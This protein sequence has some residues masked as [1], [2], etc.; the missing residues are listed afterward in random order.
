MIHE[1]GKGQTIFWN[2]SF[3]SGGSFP[4]K[5][6]LRATLR[7]DCGGAPYK[8]IPCVIRCNAHQ[9]NVAQTRYNTADVNTAPQK[10]I[11][12]RCM[13]PWTT[14]KTMAAH[15]CEKQQAI[16]RSP[17]TTVCPPPM[18]IAPSARPQDSRETQGLRRACQRLPQNC[19]TCQRARGSPPLP[20]PLPGPPRAP[21]GSQT[22]QDLPLPRALK[23]SQIPPCQELPSAYQNLSWPRGASQGLPGSPRASQSFP[24]P[25]RI[26]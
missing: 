13:T 26:S 8:M 25:P 5:C 23:A 12:I 21:H 11:N 9:H 15:S 16:P 6:F 20:Q 7:T 22:S 18:R 17:Q 10:Y 4:G 14:T 1:P 19:M 2:R 24:G 3:L